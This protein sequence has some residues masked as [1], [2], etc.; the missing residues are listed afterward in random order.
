MAPVTHTPKMILIDQNIK[1]QIH[2]HFVQN[3]LSYF[4]QIHSFLGRMRVCAKFG[5][6][7]PISGALVAVLLVSRGLNREI[8]KSFSK[9]INLQPLLVPHTW[10]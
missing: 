6:N 4:H 1:K 9:L 8:F 5:A 2:A 7:W 3:S 10:S